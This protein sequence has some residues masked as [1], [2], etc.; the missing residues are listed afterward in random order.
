VT[1]RSIDFNSLPSLRAFA[2]GLLADAGIHGTPVDV[3]AIAAYCRA[4]MPSPVY[5]GT[6]PASDHGIDGSNAAVA[7]APAVAASQRQAAARQAAFDVALAAVDAHWDE[8]ARMAGGTAN[9]IAL[10]PTGDALCVYLR[11]TVAGMLLCPPASFDRDYAA[12]DGPATG[13]DL[14]SLRRLYPW[15]PADSVARRMVRTA[16]PRT[17]PDV[18]A[19]IRAGVTLVSIW[20]DPWKPDVYPP[21]RTVPHP[22]ECQ[23][24]ARCRDSGRTVHVR[25]DADGPTVSAWLVDELGPGRTYVVTRVEMR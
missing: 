2:T 8:V 25:S 9:G 16:T 24:K 22:L 23:S 13:A 7:V 11:E 1:S 20:R 5:V 3:A 19:D 21:S 12:A 10:R 18:A 14:H 17:R 6:A 15:A 4:V